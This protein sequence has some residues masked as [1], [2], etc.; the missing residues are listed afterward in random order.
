MHSCCQ[1]CKDAYVP[2]R[3]RTPPHLEADEI[4]AAS[5]PVVL[6]M[7][8]VAAGTCWITNRRVGIRT[9]Q[10]MLE[11]AFDDMRE[12]AI[13]PNDAEPG[14][15]H[16]IIASTTPSRI[17]LMVD[18]RRVIDALARGFAASAN[19]RPLGPTTQGSVTSTAQSDA[20]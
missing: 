14:Q 13:I 2:W 4:I 7:D 5:G 6:T 10:Q 9:N 19:A 17:Q 16:C 8:S 1:V 15:W 11:L 18:R 12:L 20:N 3:Q